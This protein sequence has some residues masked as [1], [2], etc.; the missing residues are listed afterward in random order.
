M[1]FAGV[2]VPAG[3]HEIV[4]SRRIGRGWWWAAGVGVVLLVMG[5]VLERRRR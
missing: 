4:F 2:P 1:I 5:I 3:R